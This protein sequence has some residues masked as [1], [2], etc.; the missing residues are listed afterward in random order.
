MVS[1]NWEMVGTELATYCLILTINVLAEPRYVLKNIG[2]DRVSVQ[3][4]FGLERD[5]SV[6]IKQRRAERTL[7]TRRIPFSFDL[8]PTILS[9]SFLEWENLVTQ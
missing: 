7:R 8:H 2:S 1:V 6:A 3:K 4:K 5:K 9:L